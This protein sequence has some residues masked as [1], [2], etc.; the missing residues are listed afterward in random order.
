MHGIS[1][2]ILPK[3]TDTDTRLRFIQ[4]PICGWW[5]YWYWYLVFFWRTMARL[6]MSNPVSL[7]SWIFHFLLIDFSKKIFEIFFHNCQMP[8]GY[9]ELCARSRKKKTYFWWIHS[10]LRRL[11]GLEWDYCIF[12]GLG[13][14]NDE[15]YCQIQSN[16][17]WLGWRVGGIKNAG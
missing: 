13:F 3:H 4:I 5:S 1:N 7:E 10:F 12:I 11:L 15:R 8:W 6:W 17:N 2:C 16:S 14:G 9:V